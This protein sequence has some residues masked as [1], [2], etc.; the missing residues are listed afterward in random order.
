MNQIVSLLVDKL[1]KMNTIGKEFMNP[2]LLQTISAK[3]MEKILPSFVENQHCS[4]ED[5]YWGED[6]FLQLAFEIESILLMGLYDEQFRNRFFSGIETALA[7]SF[8]LVVPIY[9][10]RARV[11]ISS[12]LPPV[13]SQIIAGYIEPPM[14]G[15]SHSFLHIQ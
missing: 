10:E 14:F 5:F 7:D 4:A 2:L 9:L 1:T 6:F 8:I 11:E 3:L 15:K 12:L 13:L